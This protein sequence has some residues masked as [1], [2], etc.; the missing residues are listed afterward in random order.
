MLW[1]FKQIEDKSVWVFVQMVLEQLSLFEKTL[2][3]YLH[4]VDHIESDQK[5]SWFEG[6]LGNQLNR[7]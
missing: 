6:E 1:E 4:L 2:Q 5:I 3:R 7:T